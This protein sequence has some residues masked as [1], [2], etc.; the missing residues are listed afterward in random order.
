MPLSTNAAA[1]GAV[2]CRARCSRPVVAPAVVIGFIVYRTVAHPRPVAPLAVGVGVD[3]EDLACPL[4][5]DRLTV[6]EVEKGAKPYLLG[7]DQQPACS[8]CK[9][10]DEW[11]QICRFKA[12]QVRAAAVPLVPRQ[13][14]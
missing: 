1:A 2:S 10:K 3:D 4:R 9:R 8:N 7:G 5:Y 14:P 13:L 6:Q 12:G 11:A